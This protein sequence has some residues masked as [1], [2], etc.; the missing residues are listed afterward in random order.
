MIL[1]NE[2]SYEVRK[3][4]EHYV[5]V[6]YDN[7]SMLFLQHLDSFLIEKGWEFCYVGYNAIHD[8]YIVFRKTYLNAAQSMKVAKKLKSV[9]AERRE[10]RG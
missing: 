4:S 10:K 1:N 8:S 6:G 9:L 2:F 5:L 3:E 7:Q